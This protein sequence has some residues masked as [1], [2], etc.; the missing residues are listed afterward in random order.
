MQPHRQALAILAP[1]VEVEY[2]R[3]HLA[4]HRR[5][6]GEQRRAR[7]LHQ[8]GDLQTRRREFGKIVAEPPGERRV[9]ID[10]A[11]GGIA[12]EESRRRVIE[13]VDGVL[14]L[15]EGVLLALALARHVR[16]A[17]DCEP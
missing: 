17:P 6:A 15:D 1:Q 16:H 10:D 9:E 3:H 5:D 7:A 2:L 11:A 4:M 13:I 8:I 14:Q 12:R